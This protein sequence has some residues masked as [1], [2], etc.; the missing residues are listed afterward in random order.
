MSNTLSSEAEKSVVRAYVITTSAAI[1]ITEFC[2]TGIISG[3][4]KLQFGAYDYR[5]GSD[6]QGALICRWPQY[7]EVP[8]SSRK[9]TERLPFTRSTVKLSVCRVVQHNTTHIVNNHTSHNYLSR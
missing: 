9:A 1:E 4:A 7:E 2:C 3:H 5:I 8:L 6:L